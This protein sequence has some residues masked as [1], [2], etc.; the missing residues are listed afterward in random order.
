[1]R[2]YELRLATHQAITVSI[3]TKGTSSRQATETTLRGKLM[4]LHRC[5]SPLKLFRRANAELVFAHLVVLIIKFIVLI[6]LNKSL[7]Y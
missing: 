3:V 4:V 5:M 2:S 6:E 7:N 1:M